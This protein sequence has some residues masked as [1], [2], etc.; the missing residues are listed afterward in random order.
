MP[1]EKISAF[2]YRARQRW[3]FPSPFVNQNQLSKSA[4]TTIPKT[5][6]PTNTATAQINNALINSFHLCRECHKA[7]GTGI[8]RGKGE[9]SGFLVPAGEYS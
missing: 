2:L 5:N 8:L 7:L 9:G 1:C 4:R 6:A 3:H